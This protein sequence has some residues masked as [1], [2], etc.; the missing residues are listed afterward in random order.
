MQNRSSSR[1]LK[2]LLFIVSI[3]FSL[4]VAAQ[5]PAFTQID[6]S[7]APDVED[8]PAEEM[9]AYL[10]TLTDSEV[11]KLFALKMRKESETVEPSMM[12]SSY[13]AYAIMSLNDRSSK[14][15]E[16][17]QKVI[18][19]KRDYM[20]RLK[21]VSET[22]FI[23]Q[24]ENVAPKVIITLVILLVVGIVAVNTITRPLHPIRKMLGE[25]QGFPHYVRLGRSIAG[26]SLDLL[27][28]GLFVVIT[29]PL[30]FLFFDKFDP[31]RILSSSILV[32]TA[33]IWSIRSVFKE[34]L[35]SPVCR[36]LFIRDDQCRRIYYWSIMGFFSPKVL[37]LFQQSFL[38]LMGFQ[39][40]SIRLNTLAL[41]LVSI[42]SLII[43]VLLIAREKYRQPGQHPDI[44]SIAVLNNKYWLIVAALLGFYFI[45]FRNIVSGNAQDL[46]SALPHYNYFAL[47]MFIFMPMYLRMIYFL[48]NIQQNT[49]EILRSKGVVELN[50]TELHEDIK[51]DRWIRVIF[52]GPYIIL[53]FLY[54]MESAGIGLLSWF[55]RGAGADFGQAATG[56]FVAGML[57]VLAWNLVN[58]YINKNLPKI[59]LDPTALMDSEGGGDAAATRMQTILPI[60]RNFAL[61]LIAVIV[62]FSILSSIGANTAPLL[63]GAG[64]MGLAIGFGAQKLVQ[65]VVSGVFF[66]FEDAFR[67][68]EYIDTGELVGT[69]ESTSVRSLRLRHHLGA[70]QTIPYG[71]IRSVKNLSR[72]FVIMK[73]KFR[74]PFDTDIELVRKTIKKV[75]QQLLQHEELGDDFIAPLKSQGVQSAEDDALVIRMKFTS[76]PGKQWVIK[77]EAYRLVQEALASKGIHFASR[78]V[79]VHVPD[80]EKVD[81]E[82]LKNAV[83]AAAGMDEKEGIRN[84]ED[85]REE[86]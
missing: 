84:A 63:A 69:V 5:I 65:D 40:E 70:V 3:G 78:Q 15:E 50:G 73:L 77:R 21:L 34:M 64:V 39:P 24:G 53:I 37:S 29:V 10:A 85:S 57:G 20:E 41:S 46:D 23:D 7:A 33:I 62:S 83:G 74:V 51:P 58:I 19:A 26:I 9:D 45:G 30:T 31:V 56:V 4:S 1:L 48:V 13:I 6:E 16:E 11:R 25:K 60:V 75:G 86:R 76:K 17:F 35:Y 42:S 71:E 55:S 82:M 43:G 28:I 27:K 36:D 12:D 61:T 79:T 81:P 66:L 8:I 67:I 18:D 32:M 22:L 14:F 72:D 52:V 54:A 47:L 38:E 2:C 59:A 80:S 49:A 68:G 44:L